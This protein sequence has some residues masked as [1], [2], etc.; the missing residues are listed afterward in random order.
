M[1]HALKRRE[2]LRLTVVG[3]AL[4]ATAPGTLGW[5]APPA[6]SKLLSPGC[7]RSKVKVA[8]VY[9][10]T[11]TGQWP[12]PGLDLQA[13]IRSY[14]AAFAAMKDELAD[15]EFDADQ[16]VTTPA[17]VQ[18][19]Q[20]KL[21]GADGVLAIHLNIGV[22]AVLNA[23]L[24][25][26]KPTV[27]FAIPYSGHEWASFGAMMKQPQGEKLDCLLTTDRKQLAAAIRPFRALHH[28]REAKVLDVTT[29][30]PAQYV[31]EIKA[32]FGTEVKQVGLAEVEKAY[33]AV[34]EADARAEA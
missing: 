31:E 23:V 10:A 15:V 27:V 33:A 3:T 7:R 19:I 32:K 18:A 14:Q 26:G 5:A 21:K 20:A 25:A 6:P 11:P 22:H 29:R 17:E 2:F 8:R 34:S 16:L 9:L 1:Q 28:L 12:K 13:E 4:G 30:L 24:A